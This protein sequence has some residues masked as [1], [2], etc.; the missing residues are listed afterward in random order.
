MDDRP[1]FAFPIKSLSIIKKMVLC[2]LLLP[3]SN[4]FIKFSG[5]KSEQPK[6]I[7]ALQSVIAYS[8]T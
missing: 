8:G 3:F 2:L 5:F 4:Y 1:F 7:E 6:I